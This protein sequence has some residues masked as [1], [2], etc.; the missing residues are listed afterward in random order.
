MLLTP[1]L[2]LLCIVQQI[3]ERMLLSIEGWW[4][5]HVQET[6]E[7]GWAP[8]SCLLPEDRDQ[9]GEV[10]VTGNSLHSYNSD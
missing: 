2:N 8:A 7:Q 4:F 5:V 9:L 6:D 10:S 1:S 3:N